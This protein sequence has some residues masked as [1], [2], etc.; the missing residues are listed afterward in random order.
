MSPIQPNLV[1]FDLSCTYF[2]LLLHLF[3]VQSFFCGRRR[4]KQQISIQSKYCR[5]WL[6]Y[7]FSLNVASKVKMSQKRKN[8]KRGIRETCFRGE[9]WETMESP[10][11]SISF[12][13]LLHRS[14]LSLLFFLQD[15]LLTERQKQ[16]QRKQISL[17]LV[18]FVLVV[19]LSAC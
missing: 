5:K 13:F 8:E 11:K 14:I 4:E 7:S 9:R 16:S 12:K 18:S 19:F 17:S 3:V 15:S 1:L 6:S 2:S 10:K